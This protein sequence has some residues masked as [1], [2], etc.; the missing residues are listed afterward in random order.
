MKYIINEYMS[1]SGQNLKEIKFDKLILTEGIEDCKI[2]NKED[3]SYL[4]EKFGM[5][6]FSLEE[7]KLL[8]NL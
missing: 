4:A 2:L 1:G 8:N 7:Y 3:A 5:Y 6:A